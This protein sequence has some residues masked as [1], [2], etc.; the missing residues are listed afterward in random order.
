MSSETARTTT[1]TSRS[2]ATNGADH[3]SGMES[4]QAAVREVRSALAG[5][6]RAAPDVARVSRGA[7]DDLVRAI[8]TGS[9]E[10]V[11]AGVAISL[12]MAIGMLLGGAPRILILLALAPVAIMGI[13]QTER[14]TGRSRSSSSSAG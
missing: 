5:V 9:D 11:S 14:R 6:G 13:V 2:R 12:G 1:G 4:V 7:V 10:R 8:E 3:G